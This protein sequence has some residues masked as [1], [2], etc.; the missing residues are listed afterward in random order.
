MYGMEYSSAFTYL[1][2]DPF[3]EQL[4][5]QPRPYED[6]LFL[7]EDRMCNGERKEIYIRIDPRWIDAVFDAEE[8]SM[9]E[10]APF[11]FPLEGGLY[12]NIRWSV[13]HNAY[14]AKVP[15]YQGCFFLGA[16]F[17]EAEEKIR[18]AAKEWEPRPFEPEPACPP[19]ILG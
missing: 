9:K 14:L 7:A 19:P 5:G 15:A 6:Y 18:S 12:A 11:E 16:T 2:Y 1:L 8:E 3:S 10:P 13:E 4:E 17:Q